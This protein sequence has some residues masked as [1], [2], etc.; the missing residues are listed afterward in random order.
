[1]R[2]TVSA[3]KA[4]AVAEARTT[5]KSHFC[6][7]SVFEEDVVD[8]QS[9]SVEEVFL[10]AVEK[11]PSDR[12]AFL[13]K[14]CTDNR[15]RTRVEALLKAH[16]TAGNFLDGP[17]VRPAPLVDTEDHHAGDSFC[18]SV[19]ESL[20]F[21]AHWATPGRMGLF[22]RYEILEVLGRGGMGTMLRGVDVKL[23]C[24]VAIKVLASQL[25]ANA[26]ARGDTGLAVLERVAAANSGSQSGHPQTIGG[27]REQ[28]AGQ[29]SRRPLQTAGEV[30]ELLSRYLAHLQ[31]NPLT[32]FQAQEQPQPPTI[33][34]DRAAKQ[35]ATGFDRQ[36]GQTP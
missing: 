1:L 15:L 21:L 19:H 26:T 33:R 32:Q 20:E 31:Q 29:K 9:P 27:Y 34:E 30:A 25:A 13:D 28:A 16:D 12:P 18:T 8:T 6:I 23:N 2:D 36:P 7:D 10:Q 4:P 14:L 17:A 24:A 22:D 5:K 35:G 11:N 3:V